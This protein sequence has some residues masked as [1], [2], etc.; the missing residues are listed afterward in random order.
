MAQTHL[1]A[2]RDIEERRRL[3]TL[4]VMPQ[5]RGLRNS[6]AQLCYA[7]DAALLE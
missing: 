7:I 6:S 2:C 1:A 5:S 4:R 3:T